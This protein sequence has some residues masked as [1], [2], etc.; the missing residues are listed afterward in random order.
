L[1]DAEIVE[2]VLGGDSQA[3]ADLVVR[4]QGMVFSVCLRVAGDSSAAE[5]LAQEI[6]LKAYQSLATFRGEATFSTWLYQIAAR[7][8][9]DFRKRKVRESERRENRPVEDFI[10]SDTT[11]PEKE[12]L[13]K[14]RLEHTLRFVNELRE[15][16]RTVVRMY[17]L[18]HYSY[19]EIAEETGIP[20][21]TIESQLYRAR[22]MLK[23]MGGV[24]Q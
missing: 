4:Y 21:K 13:V 6:F 5:D 24:L 9:L 3:F 15:P 20:L 16:Y 17:Y 22:K 7:K 19:E 18:Q 23:D 14:E 12:Y 2:R 10:V 11:T 1:N 8:C